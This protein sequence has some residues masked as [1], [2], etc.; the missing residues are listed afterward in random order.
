MSRLRIAPVV[1]ALAFLVGGPALGAGRTVIKLA[2]MAPDGSI[3]HESLMEMAESSAERS[4]G[5]INIRVYPGGV[6]GDDNDMIR[7]MRIGQL[8]AASLTI[9]GLTRIDSSF[10]VFSIPMFYDSY[11]ELV[12]VLKELEPE[13]QRRL[14]EKGFV[15]V[16]WGFGGWVHLF[17]R[18]PVR[19]VDELKGVKLFTS[20]GDDQWVQ[21]WKRR[22]FR[23]VALAATDILTGLQTGM[24][25]GLPSPPLAA[26]SLQWFRHAPN[27]M[28]VG[29]GPLVGATVVSK[30][31]WNRFPEDVRAILME[32]GESVEG[33]L[34]AE[35]PVQDEDSV[36]EMEKRGLNVVAASEG[37]A[38]DSWK[39][40]AAEFSQRMRGEM[41]PDEVYDRAVRVRDA[42]RAGQADEATGS[43]SE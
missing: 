32:T 41:V 40:L 4:D 20:A 24:I 15:L 26:L 16:N 35:V 6:A 36:V 33:Q 12:H 34:L 39:E 23:P 43:T 9:S 21:W 18:E 30:R 11:D 2:T 19:T 25:D 7:K 5:A 14:D 10:M 8:H 31:A 27:M 3:W 22:G 37:D 42:F 29:I 28:D 17:T 38:A 1:I 13:L